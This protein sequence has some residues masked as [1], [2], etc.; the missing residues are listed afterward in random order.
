MKPFNDLDI[1][2]FSER[3]E[4]Y[5]INRYP[6]YLENALRLARKNFKARHMHVITMKR[7]EKWTSEDVKQAFFYNEPNFSFINEFEVLI[8]YFETFIEYTELSGAD[9]Y[10]RSKRIR[11][12][13]ECIQKTH[14]LIAIY[15]ATIITA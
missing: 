6:K 5:S 1:E 7:C 8:N 9:F 14:R 10:V 11:F 12:C 15:K 13:N 3:F 4:D 2:E